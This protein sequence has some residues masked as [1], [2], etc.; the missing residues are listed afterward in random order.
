M[1]VMFTTSTVVSP[2]SVSIDA[3]TFAWAINSFTSK[4]VSYT[5]LSPILQFGTSSTSF[6]FAPLNS[7][8]FS[9]SSSIIDNGPYAVKI[10]TIRI[11][12]T[13]RMVLRSTPLTFDYVCQ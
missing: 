5:H 2:V 9:S 11:G 3:E 10:M 6:E 13:F 12:I 4:P 8:D 7:I 1:N